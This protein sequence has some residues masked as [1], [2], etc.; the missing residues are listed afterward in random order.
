MK[1]VVITGGSEGLGKAIATRLQPSYN[2]I[3]L[4]R[5]EATLRSAAEEIGCSYKVCDVRDYAQV[6]AVVKDIGQIDCLINNAGIWL[7]G[8]LDETDAERIHEV[9]EVNTLGT[10][11]CTKAVTPGM[12][13]QKSGRIINII[14]QAGLNARAGWPVYIASKWAITGFTKSMQQELEPFGIG[15]TGMYPA[16]LTTEMFAKSGAPKDVSKDL[17]TDEVA[18]T[19]EFM[20]GFDNSVLFPEIGIKRN[21]A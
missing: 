12:K 21:K 2:V 1:T 7:Q 14:S 11:N 4:S 3:I 19:I 18:K 10:I 9:L 15:V 17:D 16:T 5:S 6:D 13:Q 20:L 8:A